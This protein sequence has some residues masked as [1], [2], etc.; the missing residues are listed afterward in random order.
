MS[1]T[2]TQS[3]LQ[4]FNTPQPRAD[5]PLAKV[6]RR[7]GMDTENSPPVR[8]IKVMHLSVVL[9]CSLFAG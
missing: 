8:K 9:I 2:S 5:S 3:P 1:R 6:S 7:M 4:L